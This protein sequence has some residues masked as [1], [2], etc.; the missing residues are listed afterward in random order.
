MELTYNEW[1]EKY[2]PI[3]NPL[4]KNGCLA[5]DIMGEQRD[6]VKKTKPPDNMD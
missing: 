4:I 3:E 2:K 5:F 6:F 1:V